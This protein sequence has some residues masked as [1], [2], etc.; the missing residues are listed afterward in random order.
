MDV[1]E[2][3]ENGESDVDTEVVKENTE[4]KL[5]V[6]QLTMIEPGTQMGFML[7]GSNG[8]NESLDGSQRD[9]EIRGGTQTQDIEESVDI[10]MSVWTEIKEMRSF[11]NWNDFFY[12]SILGFLPTFWDTFS[13]LR[14]GSQLTELGDTYSAGKITLIY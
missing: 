2:H 14:F 6:R 4:L 9:G 13:D 10:V 3:M 11:F 1:I 8:R 7:P 12:A 5:G